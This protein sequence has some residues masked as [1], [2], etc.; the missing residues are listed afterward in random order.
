[1]KIAFVGLT[2]LGLNYLSAAAFKKFEVTGFDSKN[3]IENYKNLNIEY[4]EPGLKNSIK[5]NFNKIKFSSDFEILNKFDLIFISQDIPTNNLGE[6]SYIEINKLI[7]KVKKFAN[8]KSILIILSQ[9]QPGFTRK[10]QLD[11]NRL[12]YQVET[13]IFGNS[14]E[15]AMYPER[16]IVGSLNSNKKIEKKYLKYLKSFKCPILKMNY[17]SAEFAK[18]SINLFLASSITTSNMLNSLSKKIGAKWAEIVPA[19]KLD[20]RIGQFAYIKPGL[21]ISGGNL[22]RDMNFVSK[23]LSNDKKN[24]SVINSFIEHSKFMKNWTLKILN[25]EIKKKN[26]SRKKIVLGVLGL[27]YKPNT[28]SIK[29]SPAIDLIKKFKKNTIL[30]C[31]PTVILKEKF[32]N[33]TQFKNYEEIIKKSDIIIIM[34]PWNKFKSINKIKFTSKQIVVDPYS[35]IN[36]YKNLNFKNYFSIESK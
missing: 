22:E 23:I 14:L 16:I 1:M 18:I 20:K 2:H 7:T 9:V 25:R 34:T 32:N 30:V 21:G 28:N 36:N 4:D 17:E 3:R 33:V 5:N 19:L 15:R 31:D 6:S 26:F 27:S 11:H 35:F 13:L 8:K 24:Y 10:I 29:N 12:Y